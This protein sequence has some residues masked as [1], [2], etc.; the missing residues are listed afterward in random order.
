MSKDKDCIS[1]YIQIIEL[2]EKEELKQDLSETDIAQVSAYTL[3]FAYL[4]SYG[5]VSDKKNV[6][7]VAGFFS[8]FCNKYNNYSSLPGEVN[9]SFDVAYFSETT[10]FMGAAYIASDCPDSFLLQ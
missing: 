2:F 1:N 4:E 9:L 6:E 3:R 7:E 8:Y 10:S 5:S